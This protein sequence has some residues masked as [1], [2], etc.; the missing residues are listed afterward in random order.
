MRVIRGVLYPLPKTRYNRLCLMPTEVSRILEFD[1]SALLKEATVYLRRKARVIN[2]N[3]KLEGGADLF[4]NQFFLFSFTLTGWGEFWLVR[5]PQGY[6]LYYQKDVP[7]IGEVILHH[8]GSRGT[9]LEAKLAAHFS[10][11]PE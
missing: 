2:A 4:G 7:G 3:L 6:G 1:Q 8:F 11:R 9:E 10:R 5:G